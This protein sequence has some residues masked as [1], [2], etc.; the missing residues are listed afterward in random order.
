MPDNDP[1]RGYADND[2]PLHW[3]GLGDW[4]LTWIVGGVIVLL[5]AAGSRWLK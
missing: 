1:P 3:Y 4:A 2:E 5:V